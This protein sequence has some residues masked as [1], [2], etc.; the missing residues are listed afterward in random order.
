MEN[1]RIVK[2]FIE[3]AQIDAASLNERAV[4]DAVLEKL[5]EFDCEV[6]EDDAGEKLGGNTGN[7]YA[8]FEGEL[9]GSILIGAH[10]DRVANGIG[11]KPQIVDGKIVSSGDTILAGDDLGG[12]AAILDGL[13]RLKASGIPTPRIEV[14]FIVCEEKIVLGS[15]NLHFDKLKSKFGYVID[16]PGRLGHVVYSAPSKARFT[17]EVFGKS[18]H[19]GNAPEKGI[20]AIVAASKILANIKEGRIDDETTA[21]FASFD[22]VHSVTNLVCDYAVIKGETRSISPKKFEDYLAYVEKHCHEAIEGTGAT[23]KVDITRDYSGFTIPKDGPCISLLEKVF[24]KMG[25]DIYCK[26]AGGG[27][28]ACR[29]NENGIE[30]VLV[31]FGGADNHGPKENILIED[32]VRTGEMVENM[33]AVYAEQ[34]TKK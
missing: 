12:V 7:I 2:E 29:L 10:L 1:A 6:F 20:N 18:A 26:K 32:F 4:A 27:G 33:V 28:D 24:D 30:A 14:V 23:V 9:D 17:I 31:S 11:I 34:L 19:A 21:N 13:R 15:K 16:A 5:K 22:A 8:I 25:V 3:L